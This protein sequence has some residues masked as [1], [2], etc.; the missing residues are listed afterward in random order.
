MSHTLTL[1]AG[2]ANVE[3]AR[4]VAR[5]L[6]ITLGARTVERFPDGELSV[7]LE[8]SVRGHDVYVVHPTAPPV[9]DNLMELLLWADACR[10]AAAARI[11]AIIPY[12]GY[13]RADRRQGKRGPVTARAMADALQ[14]AGVGQVV[15]VDVHSPQLEGFFHVPFEN[16]T[17]VPLMC[18]ALHEM[19]TPD[20]V[21]VAPDLGAVRLATTYGQRLGLP[22]AICRKERRSGTEVRVTRVIGDVRDH[23]C[24]VVDD[25]ITTAATVVEAIRA[26]AGEGARDGPLVAATHG[27]LVDDALGRMAHAGVR[28]LLV[29]DT[30]AARP[31]G[32]PVAM[33]TV[34]VAR[35]IA[36]A[37]RRLAREGSLRDLI[38]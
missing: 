13:A 35:L 22:V 34:S 28:E 31:D 12:V 21:V 33:R 19:V 8:E 9:N 37:I 30:I 29:T 1:F 4:E 36:E 14:R 23:P 25:M 3:L 38:A 10:R 15:T 20:T 7:Q 18:D 5:Q 6:G 27:V 16:L 11:T 17:A 26:I 32:Q 24:V 2:S